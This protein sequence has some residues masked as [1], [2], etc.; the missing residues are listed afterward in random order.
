MLA[1][2]AGNLY[3]IG[4]YMERAELA[5]RLLDV[6]GRIELLPSTG[7]GAR[8]EWD[9]ILNAT[10]NAHVFSEKYGAPVKRNVESFLFFDRDN[11]SSV[12]SCLERA[13]ENGRIV[14]TALTSQVWDT[15]NL[16]MQELRQL[17][18]T[19]RSE[20][21]LSKLIE[22]TIRQTAMLRGAIA[23]TQLR[24]DGYDFMGLGYGLERADNTARLTDVKYFVLLP[25]A[26]YVG[27]GFDT[28][29]W[30]LLLRAMSALRAFHW[31]YGGDYT[32]AK[33]VHFLILNPACPRSLISSVEQ[34]E[35]HLA[36]LA[37]RYK[38][39]TPAREQAVAL[40]SKLSAMS[41]EEIFEQ[42]LHDFLVGFQR[43]IA[44]LA[45]TAYETYL[46]GE[47]R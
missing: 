28:F 35:D 47:T 7:Q 29:Q 1:R 26:D 32:A 8:S 43:D 22:W 31:A 33:I 4:R 16:A 2:T 17:E 9:A 37:R 15:L 14:R 10:G 13:R 42:G 11:P 40:H 18:R 5:A 30:T 21:E 44:G 24:Q 3:W 12:M 25:R 38:K 19:P 6:G 39:E 46:S 41:V 34:T 27:S 36:R 20:L 23:A 45:Q